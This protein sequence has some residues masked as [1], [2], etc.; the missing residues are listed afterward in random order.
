M[1]FDLEW[2]KLLLT[3]LT[4]VSA[5]IWA[6]WKWSAERKADRRAE[7][8]RLTALY[9]NPF[10]FACHDLQSRLYN[11][12]CRGGL[13]ALRIRGK[14][15]EE[16]LYLVAQYFAFEPFVL[17]YTPYGTDPRLLKL[18]EQIRNDFASAATAEDIDP[19]CIFR[20]RQRALGRAV[21][22]SR[23][24]DG[25]GDLDVIPLIDFEKRIQDQAESLQVKEA[26]SNL[27]GVE[28]IVE[29]APRTR[30]RLAEV[31][32]HLVEIL[33]YL[34]DELQ[35]LRTSKSGSIIQKIKG[36]TPSR[37]ILGNRRSRALDSECTRWR[38]DPAQPLS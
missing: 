33:D 32:S 20:L 13:G 24:A 27:E 8:N 25:E 28:S 17:R 2:A 36:T 19:W 7:Q 16:L 15:A 10:L 3:L 14:H 11:I 22:V 29:L 31:Q 6:I 26:L 5:A 12:L 1:S 35:D 18:I 30:R 23:Q 9:V 38:D 34:E 4:A 37:P 21:L